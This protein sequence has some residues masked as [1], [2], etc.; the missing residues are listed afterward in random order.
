MEFLKIE[1]MRITIFLFVLF[2]SPTIFSQKFQVKFNQCFQFKKGKSFNYESLIEKGG[3]QLDQIQN[4][5][6][7]YVFDLTNREALL[8]FRG[9]L[10][11][12]ISIKKSVVEGDLVKVEFDDYDINNGSTIPVICVLNNGNDFSV[13]PYFMFYYRFEGNIE[14]NVVYENQ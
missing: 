8:Y 5:Q 14:G 2:V 3:F 4:G 7:M 10:V 13:Y 11:R 1:I 9:N 6:N 12:K